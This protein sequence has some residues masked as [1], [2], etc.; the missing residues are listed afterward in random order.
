MGVRRPDVALPARAGR[1]DHHDPPG[2]RRTPIHGDLA[3][4]KV[5]RVFSDL[6]LHSAAWK[7]L[8]AIS[9]D[10]SDA[11]RGRRRR[12]TVDVKT[13]ARLPSTSIARWALATGEPTTAVRHG[14][15]R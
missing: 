9:V 11:L 10:R 6:R 2:R 1:R 15:P 12:K 13:R 3:L 7:M 14:P 4:P 5:A 8:L